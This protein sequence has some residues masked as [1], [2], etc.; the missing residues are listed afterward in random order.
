M[1]VGCL[2]NF[3]AVIVSAMAP[4]SARPWS[5]SLRIRRIAAC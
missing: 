1:S 5:F 2:I 4:R 3:A